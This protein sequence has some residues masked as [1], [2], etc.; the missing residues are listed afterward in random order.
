MTGFSR[1]ALLPVLFLSCIGIT[2]CNAQAGDTANQQPQ[3]A[4]ASNISEAGLKLIP[5]SISSADSSTA[6]QHDFT[7]E[8]AGTRE[9][10]AQGLMFRKE[11][12]LD[13]G[14]LFPFAESRRANFWMKN[15]IIPLDIIFIR[16]DGS[17][18][19]IA[20]NTTPYSLDGVESGE[21]VTAVLELA[22]GRAA[23]LGI[24]PGDIVKWS[25]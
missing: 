25:Q 15:T 1:Q 16:A 10:Q 20:A 2:G 19:S 17:I 14:M 8:V 24:E 21:P 22:G 23:E 9:E 3:V 7:V 13:K 5:L 18:E 12:A 11:L 4:E 6:K